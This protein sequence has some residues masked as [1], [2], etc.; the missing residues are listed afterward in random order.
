M[1][2]LLNRTSSST[3]CTAPLDRVR[4]ITDPIG[5]FKPMTSGQKMQLVRIVPT[6]PTTRAL[7]VGTSYSNCVRTSIGCCDRQKLTLVG[8]LARPLGDTTK[9]EPKRI[10]A[11]LGTSSTECARQHRFVLL[12]V[13]HMFGQAPSSSP[14][15]RT[16]CR[17]RPDS[18][19]RTA[20]TIKTLP[21]IRKFRPI[22]RFGSVST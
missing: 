6:R 4:A 3:V 11:K 1:E 5:H 14:Q 9:L 16:P 10:A 19:N 7:S 21:N 18:A 15:F 13:P 8:L 22:M 12:I 17:S 2:Q 20:A